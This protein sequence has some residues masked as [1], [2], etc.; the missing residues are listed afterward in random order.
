MVK[1]GEHVTAMQPV[2]MDVLDTRIE[3]GKEK[4]IVLKLRLKVRERKVGV[5]Y[6]LRE[7]K[8]W[9]R[10]RERERKERE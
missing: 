10:E 2:T 9:T 4:L 1:V 8:V 5:L 7:S 6:A 3:G